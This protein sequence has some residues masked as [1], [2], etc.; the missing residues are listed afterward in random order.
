MISSTDYEDPRFLEALEALHNIHPHIKFNA[1][2]VVRYTK[3]TDEQLEGNEFTFWLMTRQYNGS[4]D[5]DLLNRELESRMQEQEENQSSWSMQRFV[6]RTMNTH[7]YYPTVGYTTKV[8][9][10]SRYILNI[11]NTD[12]KCLLCCLIAY[13][14]PA[15]D[16]PNIFGNYN[17]AEYINDIKLPKLQPPYG[18]KE[19]QKIQK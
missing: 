14:H 16:H 3:P 8:P 19:L 13:L 18:Y 9:F 11:H 17:K 12:N 1:F 5:L 15:I 6:K 7:R 10:T 4:Y 2:D